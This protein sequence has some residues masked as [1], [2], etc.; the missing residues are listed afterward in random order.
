MVKYI[1]ERLGLPENQEEIF[2][3]QAQAKDEAIRCAV[4]GLMDAK[5]QM[6][7]EFGKYAAMNA[8]VWLVEELTDHLADGPVLKIKRD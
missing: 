6:E 1:L 2:G 4:K 7:E 5:E 8:M 3:R